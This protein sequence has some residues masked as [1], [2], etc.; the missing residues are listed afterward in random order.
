M[1]V[2]CCSITSRCQAFLRFAQPSHGLF[3]LENFHPLLF[4]VCWSHQLATLLGS[5]LPF[6]G[7]FLFLHFK[8]YPPSRFPLQNTPILSSP[9][10]PA[11]MRVL[12]HPPTY[13]L[14]PS[15]PGFSLHWVI[16]T[17]QDQGPLLPLMSYKAILCHI[18]SWS[19]GSL[20]V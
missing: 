2:C 14:P 5:P 3:L 18:C 12:L 4:W 13:S 19:H 1:S 11:S 20:H 6:I 9:P 17:P 8:C 16:K 7:Y 15:C 10:C